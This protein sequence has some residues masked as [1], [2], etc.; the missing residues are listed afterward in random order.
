MT[1]EH[2]DAAATPPVLPVAA[3]HDV[4]GY[5]D[6]ITRYGLLQ[7][8][9]GDTRDVDVVFPQNGRDLVRLVNK[10]AS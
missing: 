1:H 9:L 4:S 5:V 10:P 6:D 8:R 3:M 2:S 7:P